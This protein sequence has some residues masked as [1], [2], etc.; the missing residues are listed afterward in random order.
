[1]L[2]ELVVAAAVVMVLLGT[3]FTLVD[4]A[5]GG[6]GVQ[7]EIAEMQQRL[8]S[9]F[10]RLQTDL[11]LAGSGPHASVDVSVARLR[12]PVVPALFGHR[13][14]LASGATFVSDALTMM[15]APPGDVATPLAGA[16]SGL[17]GDVPL[18]PDGSRCRPGIATCGFSANS[19]ALMFDASGR[20]DIV[21]V[22]R[23]FDGTL[24][25]R[26]VGEGPAQPF[27]AGAS[28][29]PIAVRGYYHDRAS[30]RLRFQNG[31]VTDV[32]VLDDVVGLSIRYFGRPAL[33]ADIRAGG[34]LAPCLAAALAAQP[35]AQADTVQSEEELT[36][37]LLTDGPWCGG[38]FR[39]D[40][41]LFR[42]RRIRV[43]IRL[44][45]SAARHRGRDPALFTRPGSARHS[46]APDLVGIIEVTPRTLP[47][48]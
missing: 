8:R 17:P 45:A 40:A 33:S 24:R 5:R 36:A 2:A 39:Y 18:A 48:F 10:V 34:P 12:P 47:G 31:W 23:V 35:I 11:L 14:A 1:M 26:P 38:R 7:P 9:G 16:F 21:R 46:L 25:I 27:A 6:L 29:M 37:A 44:Q 42:V 32:P 20:S 43:E 3:V 30:A 15:Y 19:L 22:L 41:D 13:H 4:P 28:I